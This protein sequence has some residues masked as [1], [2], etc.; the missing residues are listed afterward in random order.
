MP[1]DVSQPNDGVPQLDDRVSLP[2]DRVQL[3]SAL[4]TLIG[5]VVEDHGAELVD[6]ELRGS[7]NNQ[8]VR[9]LVHR[10]P[11]VM[12]HDCEG[13]SR[14]VAD[15]LDIDDPIPGRYRLEVTSPGLDRPLTTDRDLAR[16]S[17]RRLK[18]ALSSGGTWF[19]RLSGWDV[20]N[21]T[22]ETDTG[23]EV[24]PRDEIAKA[25]VEVEL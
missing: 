10:E 2:S 18:V 9:I 3:R 22:L 17:S 23:T 19:G 8:T 16:A 24:I 1:D 20:E 4:M 14:E 7:S 15:L 13:I 25:T 6:V 21:I 12:L 5:P 11:G